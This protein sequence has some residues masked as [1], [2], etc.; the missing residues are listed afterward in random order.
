M[1]NRLRSISLRVLAWVAGTAAVVAA[2]AYAIGGRQL[3]R[4]L[5]R[6]RSRAAAFL[7]P[8]T[9]EEM[10]RATAQNPA[11]TTSV[12]ALQTVAPVTITEIVVWVVAI[13]VVI[14]LLFYITG[15]PRRQ[16]APLPGR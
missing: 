3:F 2:A 15:R 14:I 10:Q 16:R 5:L 6:A 1:A 7:Q 13:L 9:Q 4:N 12:S 8:P 11:S